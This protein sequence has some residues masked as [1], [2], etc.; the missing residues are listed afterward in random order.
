MVHA[1]DG[2]QGSRTADEAVLEELA[3]IARTLAEARSLDEVL[4]RIVDLGAHHLEHCD[5]VSLMLIQ[6]GGRLSTPAYSSDVARATDRV[7]YETDEGPCLTSMSSHRTVVIDD[8]QEE[9]RWPRFAAR[10]LELGVR[11]MCSFRLFMEQD[12]LGALNFYASRP[13]AFGRRDVLLGEVFASHAAV[14]LR[15]AITENGLEAAL[16]SRDV[17]GQAKG[18]IMQR[19]VV[20]ADEAFARLRELSERQNRPLR[21]IAD[22]VVRTGEIPAPAPTRRQR[23]G[24]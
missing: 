8:L 13:H 9:G 1:E 12:T 4:Q 20:T 11:S 6:R 21:D 17:I 19:D 23:R 24:A 3:R 15:A 14:A 2:P 5:G 7:Q 10:V 22:D 18:V 16:R